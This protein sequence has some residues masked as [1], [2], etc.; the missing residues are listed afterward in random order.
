MGIR[1]L[2]KLIKMQCNNAIHPMHL[3][4]LS[5][6][7]IA[8]DTSIYLYKFEGNG[9][10]MEGMY[11]MLSA[12][13]R[14]NIDAIF[15][16][17]GKPPA[18]KAE[19]LK[20]RKLD[21]WKNNER[22]KELLEQYETLIDKTAAKNEIHLL[23]KQ[24][25][26][27]SKTKTENVIKLVSSFGMKHHVAQGEADQICA[28]LVASGD[29]WACLS[30]DTDMFVYACP[31]VLRY[32]NVVNHSVTLYDFKQ[33]L[34]D[35]SLSESNFKKMCVLSGTDYNVEHNT[36]SLPDIW[37]QYNE[38]TINK[39][40]YEWYKDEWYKDEWNKDEV[41]SFDKIQ[42]IIEMFQ[43]S[44]HVELPTQTEMSKKDI[45]NI[46]ETHNFIFMTH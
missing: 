36:V 14:Y 2:N 27:I 42:E 40:F 35:L 16:F 5:G 29:A 12:F 21:K 18:E 41:P 20:Q 32:F 1:H 19:L 15:V 28:A 46:M 43:P 39:D 44:E 33:I 24:C 31:R 9:D 11:A 22:R 7:C 13:V 10:L 26:T 30:E 6:K 8:I 37:K 38:S 45:M 34:N 23:N 25:A 3:S 17:D 4:E